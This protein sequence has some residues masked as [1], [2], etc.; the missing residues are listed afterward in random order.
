M[1]F[2]LNDPDN[3]NSPGAITFCDWFLDY[4]M[5]QDHRF[6]NDVRLQRLKDFTAEF[7]LGKWFEIFGRRAPVDFLSLFDSTV[8]HEVSRRF[9]PIYFRN[10]LA[11]DRSKLSKCDVLICVF[12]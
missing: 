9:Q 10:A 6:L 11:K 2:E 5:R 7:D 4:A 8:I 3:L 1:A 12:S